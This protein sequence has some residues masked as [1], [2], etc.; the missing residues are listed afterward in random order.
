M[1]YDSATLW[2]ATR[3]DRT[4]D[5]LI[6]MG[7]SRRLLN[8]GAKQ[9]W[10]FVERYRGEH[11]SVPPAGVV[12]EQCNVPIH[13][14]TQDDEEA[15][16]LVAHS[17]V[18]GQLFRRAE[19]KALTYGV[20]KAAEALEKDQQD[21]AREE[22]L[23]LADH[24]K[25]DKAQH[26]QIHTLAS[27]APEVLDFYE[28]VERGET[29]VPFPWPIMT[30]MTLGMWP[31]TLTFFV[32]R[33]GVG[34]T[35]TAVM[36]AMH[37]WEKAKRVLIISPELSRVELGERM[38]AKYGRIPYRDMIGATLPTA[39]IGAAGKGHLI[40]VIDELKQ[41]GSTLFVLDNEEFLT[42]DNIEAAIRIVE[43]ELVL[44]DSIYMLR[45][46]EGKIKA[47][48]GGNGKQ[49]RMERLIST[50]DWMRKLSRRG[51]AFSPEGLPLVGIHQ[52]ARSGKVRK[53]ASR[54]LKKGVGT[55][56]LEDA[57]ALSDTLFWNAHTLFA[58]HQDEYM[59][60]DKQLLYVPLKVRRMVSASSLAIQ[61]D[62]DE[63]SFEQLGTR[64]THGEYDD[65]EDE[66]VPY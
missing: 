17:Y 55:G 11:G 28:R 6:K 31:G 38:V 16:V 14:P 65:K 44:F 40:K 3:S 51:W 9:A 58:M 41:V 50:I 59:R 20:G 61:W 29:G 54:S 19:F 42:P 49:D 7:V 26:L 64:V 66:E 27:I 18:V 25:S 24:L 21:A 37:A 56:G 30:N 48:R 15:G 63:M 62:L 35:W 46:E 1:D 5:A 10:D 33:P 12:A 45:V 43:P 52:L 53:E 2:Y 22:V 47:P 23:K 60:Q 57:V 13:P 4:F 32:A 39:N 34:K 8:G 36:I